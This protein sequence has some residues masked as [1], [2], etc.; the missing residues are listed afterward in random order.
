MDKLAEELAQKQLDA[1]N[2]QN[3]DDFL[4]CYSENVIVREFPSNNI[5]YQG[6]EMMR[7]RYERLFAENPNNHAKILSRITKGNVAID[8]EYVTGRSNGNDLYA[9]AMYEIQHN[10]IETVWFIV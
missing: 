5:M 2:E 10:K 8:H 7:A 1:Y 9:V 3:I 6:K 4:Q